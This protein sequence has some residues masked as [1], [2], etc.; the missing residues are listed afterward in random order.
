M[1][2]TSASRYFALEMAA[3]VL[4]WMSNLLHVMDRL[5]TSFWKA[6]TAISMLSITVTKLEMD[7]GTWPKIHFYIAFLS[8]SYHREGEGL[9]RE[10]KAR[11]HFALESGTYPAPESSWSSWQAGSPLL[12]LW[13]LEDLDFTA[14]FRELWCEKGGTSSHQLKGQGV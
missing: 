2:T 3:N 12:A 11:R 8:A 7:I 10:N 1:G 9:R 14:A 13:L 5:Y 4:S 6:F